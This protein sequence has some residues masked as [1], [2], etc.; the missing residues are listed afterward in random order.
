MQQLS[1]AM[2]QSEQSLLVCHPASS[3]ATCT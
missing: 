3:S 1:L 2:R